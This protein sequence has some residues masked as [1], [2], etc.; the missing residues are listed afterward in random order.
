MDNNLNENS[1]GNGEKTLEFNTNP[2]NDDYVIYEDDEPLDYS[3]DD[4]YSDD[5]DFYDDDI[6]DDSLPPNDDNQKHS[7]GEAKASVLSHKL[8]EEFEGKV[9]ALKYLFSGVN[10]M[11][12]LVRLFA[13]YFIAMLYQT[14]RIQES[15]QNLQFGSNVS[16]TTLIT[17][18]CLIFIATSF[19]KYLVNNVL[20]SALNTDGYFLGTAIMLYGAYTV[21]RLNNFYYALG[22][23]IVVATVMVFLVGNDYFKEFKTLSKWQSRTIVLIFFLCFAIGVGTLCV[24]RYLCY[25]TSCF[26]FGI[27]C[28]MYHYMVTHGTLQT[29]CERNYL[30][31]HFA[32]H[33]SPIYYL[34]L[35]IFALFQSPITLLICQA[36]I[37]ASGVIPLYLICK[38]FKFSNAVSVGLCALLVF[39]P[40]L[41]TSTFFDFH[42]NK[43]LVPLI[44]WAFWAMETRHI[45]LMYLFAMLVLLVKEDAFVYVASMALFLTFSKKTYYSK[46]K[47]KEKSMC[48]HGVIM[49]VM[50]LVYF[51]IVS[52]LMEKYG[53][54]VMEYR[55]SNVMMDADAGLTNVIKTLALN[56]ALAIYEAFDEDKILF[57]LQMVAPLLFLPFINKKISH[58]FLL[59]PFFLVNLISDYSYQTQIGYQYVCGVTSMLI[60]LS[61]LNLNE[62]KNIPKRYVATACMC[63]SMVIGFMYFSDKFIYYDSYCNYY[64]RIMRMNNLLSQI[65]DDASVECTTYYVPQL[66]QRDELYMLEDKEDEPYDPTD[67]IVIRVGSG[68]ETFTEDKINWATDHGY[69]FYNGYSD[70]MYVFVK[71]DY[72]EQH[73]ELRDHQRLS[74][75]IWEE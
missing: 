39:S 21:F 40:S 67:F 13:S 42:E 48:L 34:L 47:N 70:L 32:V 8:P 46:K 50:S 29:T 61:V 64:G 57:F 31:S 20:K 49:L 12:L 37:V 15:F 1:N 17:Q 10:F 3:D 59:I 74:P 9:Q 27:F 35:P 33:T 24:Y 45:K 43:F 26:D 7:K 54:G 51:F 44:L 52:K 16:V 28:Q 25:T 69:E 53:L 6:E 71:S 72:I 68:E 23:S 18:I 4:Y 55:Y 38:N 56:P 63:T 41:I 60:Y 73:E 22:V 30:L 5:D 75:I 65:P 11:D 58:V 2:I 14:A 62:F 19:V 66:S 36:I